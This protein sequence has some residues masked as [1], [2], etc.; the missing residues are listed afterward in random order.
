MTEFNV[1]CV[2]A[3]AIHLT[4]MALLVMPVPIDLRSDGAAAQVLDLIM[5]DGGGETFESVRAEVFS[6][7][8]IMERFEDA[9]EEG[10]ASFDDYMTA[11][12]VF[13]DAFFAD[14][15]AYAREAL[16][17]L[18]LVNVLYQ[19]NP[20]MLTF[21]REF[22]SVRTDKSA[23]R[24]GKFHSFDALTEEQ[25]KLTQQFQ[26]DTTKSSFDRA[27]FLRAG[28]AA[29]VEGACHALMK[30][31]PRVTQTRPVTDLEREVLCMVEVLKRGAS[32][33]RV[34]KDHPRHGKLYDVTG[35]VERDVK[36][37]AH[38]VLAVGQ[39]R[40]AE[41]VSA[42]KN[43]NLY[44]PVKESVYVARDKKMKRQ[45]KKEEIEALRAEALKQELAMLEEDEREGRAEA[46]EADGG[47]DCA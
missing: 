4:Q 20:E 3:K 13:L 31:N 43:G 16:N 1:T 19:H 7:Q 40:K 45:K 34:D 14:G 5:Q 28:P 8:L 15:R 47:D 32:G 9:M 21:L 35:K 10:P 46:G 41:H 2:L 18:L 30:V 39:A 25:A 36:F 23:A 44:L 29:Q 11:L 22:T 6:V 26:R 17:Y 12:K 38:R 37:G 24:N 33:Q 42:S 27:N